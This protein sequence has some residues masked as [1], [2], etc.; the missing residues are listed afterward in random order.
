MKPS[1]VNLSHEYIFQTYKELKRVL[2]QGFLKMK[3]L[4]KERYPLNK[5]TIINEIEKNYKTN[6]IN[7]NILYSP[8]N[9][10]IFYNDDE[11]K[12]DIENKL[13]K[14]KPK[15][16][17]DIQFDDTN[18]Q[19]INNTNSSTEIITYRNFRE[20]NM[21]MIGLNCDI[22]LKRS[23]GLYNSVSV[24]DIDMKKNIYLPRIIDR[25]KYSIPRNLRN[26]KGFIVLGKNAHDML[27]KYKE[28]KFINHKNEMPTG[29]KFYNA[30]K[31]EKNKKVFDKSK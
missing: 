17:G 21:K 13:P 7:K 22:K 9:I 23:K 25:M 29:M 30:N 28:L 18:T 1:F 16:T 27:N 31:I 2:P 5:S 8:Q 19:N 4:K 10:N 6:H 14:I 15:K 3:V 12:D 26:N 11:N 20:K 24:S